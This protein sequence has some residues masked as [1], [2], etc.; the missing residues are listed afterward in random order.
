[1]S[2]ESVQVFDGPRSSID[3]W[4]ANVLADPYATYA[5]LR[6]LGPAVWLDRYNM[7]AVPRFAEVKTVLADWRNFSSASRVG[8]TPDESLPGPPGLLEMDPPEH[9]AERQ[10]LMKRLSSQRTDATAES[11]QR[12]AIDTVEP[13]IARDDVNAVDEIARPY[14]LAVISELLGYS[15]SSREALP[16]LA[17]RGFDTFGPAG[18]QQQDGLQAFADI[19]NRAIEF[20]AAKSGSGELDPGDIGEFVTYAFPG[21]DT[22]IQAINSALYHFADHPDHW[23]RLRESPELCSAASDEVLRLY[24]PIRHFTRLTTASVVLGGITVPAGTRLLVMYGSANR[25]ERHFPNP[26]QF[27]LTRP[28]HQHLAF[29]HGVHRCVGANLA[30]RELNTLL[31]VLVSRVSHIGLRGTPVWGK[32]LTIH[33]LDRL[34]I[35]MAAV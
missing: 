17:A 18:A 4:D 32:S 2:D 33:G 11:I 29:G 6:D 9:T 22:T 3:L 30:S 34:H 24:S 31:E 16:E 26:D 27:D 14:I 21:M 8:A 12:E 20:A 15:D 5:Q 1:M 23:K 7:V 25:D 10:M 35:S 19:V 13:L 28:S